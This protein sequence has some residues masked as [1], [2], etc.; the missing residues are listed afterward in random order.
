MKIKTII[1]ILATFA[2]IYF[3]SEVVLGVIDA[4]NS[5]CDTSMK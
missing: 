2:L 4:I 3:L 5:P 1:Y